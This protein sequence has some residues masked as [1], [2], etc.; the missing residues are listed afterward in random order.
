MQDVFYMIIHMIKQTTWIPIYENVMFLKI[1]EF[2]LT[3]N[4]INNIIIQYFK[5]F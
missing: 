1:E 3:E 2:N 5:H 4:K